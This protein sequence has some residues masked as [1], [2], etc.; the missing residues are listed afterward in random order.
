MLLRRIL[1]GVWVAALSSCDD[2]AP[3]QAATG[4]DMPAV[5]GSCNFMADARCDEYAELQTSTGTDQ[6]CGNMGGT[7]SS[8]QCP[9]D[10]RSA[11]C[12]QS[13]PAT[14]TYAYSTDAATA[15]ASN[16]AG[17]KFFALE[18]ACD[19]PAKKLCDEYT[20]AR[21]SGDGYMVAPAAPGEAATKCT[22]TG[23]MWTSGGRCAMAGRAASCA[24]NGQASYT[25]AYDEMSATKLGMT[26]MPA[27]FKRIGSTTTTPPPK[28][29][30][31][32]AGL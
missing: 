11:V 20:G 31:E 25:Y 10:K 3:N 23:G 27:N 32:D 7:W 29:S 4:E 12:L 13:S 6:T 26:C 1:I 5:A 8:S 19:T 14:R 18:G 22:M 15:L 28:P 16:C 9:L 21:G 24:S 30:D 2:G 17:G